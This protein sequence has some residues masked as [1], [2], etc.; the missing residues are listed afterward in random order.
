MRVVLRC[1]CQ[2][3]LST[4]QEAHAKATM[5]GKKFYVIGGKHITLDDRFIAAEIGNREREIA[6][7]EKR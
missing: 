1:R 7:M 5:Y 3:Q 6:E 2:K 4:W